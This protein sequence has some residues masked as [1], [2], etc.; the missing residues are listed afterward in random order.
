[1]KKI[2]IA[3]AILGVT[4]CLF[5]IETKVTRQIGTVS[6]TYDGYYMIVSSRCTQ[7][8]VDETDMYMS[9]VEYKKRGIYLSECKI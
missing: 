3:T 7:E 4:A 1:M 9:V 8:K 6:E 2:A 5:G